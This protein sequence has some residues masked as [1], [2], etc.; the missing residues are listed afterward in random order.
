MGMEKNLIA[1]RTQTERK[2]TELSCSLLL[3]QQEPIENVQGC[4]GSRQG[5]WYEIAYDNCLGFVIICRLPEEMVCI[6]SLL[7]LHCATASTR[8]VA[9][10]STSAGAL[11]QGTLMWSVPLED[12]FRSV[13]PCMEVTPNIY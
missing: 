5:D 9:R 6:Q 2:T 12:R 3:K 1:S 4:Q 11:L 10:L 7:P 8:M 13:R